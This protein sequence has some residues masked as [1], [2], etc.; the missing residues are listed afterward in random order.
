MATRS[1]AVPKIADIRQEP[2][3]R[4]GGKDLS[5]N[6]QGGQLGFR[7]QASELWKNPLL[8]VYGIL[9]RPLGISNGA[10]HTE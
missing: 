4:E 9:R 7:S 10:P 2:G 5:Q 3:E 1:L 6:L 8:V